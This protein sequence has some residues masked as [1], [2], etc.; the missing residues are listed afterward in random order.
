M[1]SIDLSK[2]VDKSNT[3]YYDVDIK[4]LDITTSAVNIYKTY[5]LYCAV[6]IKWSKCYCNNNKHS[7]LFFGL[8]NKVLIYLFITK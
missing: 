8:H 4:W 7:C 2:S 3:K 5:T 6:V 1:I